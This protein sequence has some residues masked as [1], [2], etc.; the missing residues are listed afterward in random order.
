M[1]A[2][3]LLPLP[4]HGA[5]ELVVGIAAMVASFALGFS[6]AG[7]VVGFS[8]GAAIVGLALGSTHDARGLP[9]LRIATHRAADYGLALGHSASALLLAIVGDVV[10]GLVLGG[11]SALY[12]LINVST[13]YTA[14]A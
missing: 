2:F 8:V 13:R 9:A 1:T 12:M 4:I 7:T 14:R 10:A 5:L 3:R 6:P 11:L